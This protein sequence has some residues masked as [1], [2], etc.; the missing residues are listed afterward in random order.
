MYEEVKRSGLRPTFN[1]TE[2]RL[3]AIGLMW[4]GLLGYT[5]GD[6]EPTIAPVCSATIPALQ[7]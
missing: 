2:F 1:E 3:I 5:K 4:Y 6:C 7:R